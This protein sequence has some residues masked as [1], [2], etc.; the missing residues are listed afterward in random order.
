MGCVRPRQIFHPFYYK[1]QFRPT[2]HHVVIAFISASNATGEG[3]NPI[4]SYR[5]RRV[6]ALARQLVAGGKIR[7]P[8]RRHAFSQKAGRQCVLE[9]E[10][11]LVC[12]PRPHT[13][14]HAQKEEDGRALL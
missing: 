7:L 5:R 14:P 3:L 11:R 6:A 10:W 9:P 8:G 2:S 13:S 12:G 1:A 4:L